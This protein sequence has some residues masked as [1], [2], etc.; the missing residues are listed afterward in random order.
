MAASLKTTVSDDTMSL[1]ASDD[2]D[3]TPV[4][5]VNA[6]AAKNPEADIDWDCKTDQWTMLVKLATADIDDDVDFVKIHRTIFQLMM[7]A[8]ETTT[9]RTKDGTILDSTKNF[10]K[11]AAYKEAFTTRETKTCF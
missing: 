10:P 6:R 8:D 7:Q 3:K 9:F 2:A 1:T 5:N 11:G 4:N